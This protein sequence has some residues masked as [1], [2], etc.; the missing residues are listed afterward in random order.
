MPANAI[1]FSP[2]AAQFVK[3][4]WDMFN[5]KIPPVFHP[6]IVSLEIVRMDFSASVV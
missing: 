3:D 4:A 2:P 1:V 5:P 6:I